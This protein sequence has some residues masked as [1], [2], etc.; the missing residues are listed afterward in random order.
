GREKRDYSRAA[1]V[2]KCIRAGGKHNDLDEVGRD[3]R[4]L[5][6]FEMLGNWSFGDYFK[7]ESIEWAWELLTKVWGLDPN[8]LHATYFGGDP[9]KGLEPDLEARTLWLSIPGMTEARVHPGNMK[10][11]FWEMG[12]TGPCGPCSEVH[13]DLTP[14]LSGGPLVNAGDQRVIEIWNL[15]FIQYNRGPDKNLTPLPDKHV[16]TGM[17]LERVTAVIQGHNNNYAT[18]VFKQIVQSI[19]SLTG[20]QYGAKASPVAGHADNRYARFSI[21][22]MGDVACRVIAD[23]IRT[24]TFA[25]TDG[26]MPDKDGRGYVLRRILRRAVRY[27]WQ[28]LNLHEPFLCRLAPVVVEAMGDA[29]SKLRKSPARVVEVIREEEESFNRTLDRGL[30]LF[31]NAAETAQKHSGREI[32]GE[33]AFKLYDTFGF[34]RDLTEIMARERGLG[35]DHAEYDRLMEQARQ[36]SRAAGKGDAD[37][38]AHVDPSIL[39]K[40][41]A[42]EDSAKYAASHTSAALR[43]ILVER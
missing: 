37:A 33:D 43:A 2:Q 14:D 39:A 30:A 7:K 12:E 27:G 3:G 13:V 22:D 41:P 26:A 35:V 5:T 11:N 34:P 42:T 38:F 18:D 32:S 4:H 24:L 9:E 15:V 40:L 20:H 6:F 23:H 8:R 25:L 28:H 29:F 10:D 16:D 36:R 1:S 21:D 17:G 19:E 31:E